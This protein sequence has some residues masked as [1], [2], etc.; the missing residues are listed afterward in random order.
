[1]NDKLYNLYNHPSTKPT[2]IGVLSFSAGLGVGYYL[3]KKPKVEVHVTPD[4]LDMALKTDDLEKLK[5][6]AEKHGKDVTISAREAEELPQ[7]DGKVTDITE[8]HGE[9]FVT[10]KIKELTNV[11]N[12]NVVEA[13]EE[14]VEVVTRSV[15]AEDNW[16]YAKELENR[17]PD[18]PYVIHKDEFYS[19]ESG[20]TQ[21][22]LTYYAGDDILVDEDDTPIY[23]HD[24]VIGS[25]IKFGHGSGDPNVVHIRNDRRR[26]EYEVIFDPSLYSK[27]V[28]GIEIENNTRVQDLRHSRMPLKFRE[29]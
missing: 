7:V 3:W 19:E 13:T 26:A 20:Y 4:Q 28:L 24:Q 6:I 1:M 15:F 12:N 14:V 18:L 17:N 22:T 27:E 16:D 10:Q 25:P 11:N 23:N 21:S 9:S 8:L 2:L 29:E 5:N